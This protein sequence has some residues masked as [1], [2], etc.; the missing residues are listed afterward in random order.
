MSLGLIGS[1]ISALSGPLGTVAE[2]YFD[3]KDDAAAFKNAVELEVLKN[4]KSVEDKAG[5]I[6]LAEARSEHWLTSTWRPLM[7]VI[8]VTVIAIHILIIPYFLTPILWMFGA[9][10]PE[11]MP[12]PEQVWTLLTIGIGGY[13]GGRSIEKATKHV[14]QVVSGKKTN[15]LD[16]F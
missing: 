6:I 5:S 10:I 3:N 2:R 11:L 13:V 16:D 12:I 15:N 8:F 1:I 4:A 7:M 14:A 9:P